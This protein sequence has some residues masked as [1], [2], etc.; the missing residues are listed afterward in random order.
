MFYSVV[1]SKLFGDVPRDR[2][3]QWFC[4]VFIFCFVVVLGGPGG[5]G[6][7]GDGFSDTVIEVLASYYCY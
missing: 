3:E 7:P 6:A 4:L 5:F 1:H 2:L